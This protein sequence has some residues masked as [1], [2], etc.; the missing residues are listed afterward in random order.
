MRERMPTTPAEKRDIRRFKMVRTSP[1]VIEP[2]NRRLM[3]DGASF[4]GPTQSAPVL[5]NHINLTSHVA[6]RILT[7]WADRLTGAIVGD[8]EIYP[9]SIQA[10]ADVRK[11]LAAG[12]RGSSI[13]FE[14]GR[15]QPNQDGSTGIFDW[16]LGHL[17]I[18]GQGAD[19][20]SWPNGL[21]RRR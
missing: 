20:E 19:P 18:V 9:D 21:I 13:N 16:E 11:L 7:A 1:A 8:I 2:A 10:A 12:H 3:F 15:R 4:R 14:A 6:G 17:A 5:N